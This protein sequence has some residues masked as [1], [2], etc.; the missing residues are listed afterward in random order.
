VRGLSLRQNFGQSEAKGIVTT[1]R[2]AYPKEAFSVASTLGIVENYF[3]KVTP[4]VGAAYK[5]SAARACGK[6]PL[7]AAGDLG[8]A[9]YSAGT[10]ICPRLCDRTGAKLPRVMNPQDDDVV[11]QYG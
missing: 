8:Q 9:S 6:H 7:R 2:L 4:L 3:L 1:I 10:C 11:T 5:P